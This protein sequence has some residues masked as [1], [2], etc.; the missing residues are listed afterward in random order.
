M[1]LLF[2]P[3]VFTHPAVAVRLGPL[4]RVRQEQS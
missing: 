4:L 1:L 3:E 2:P